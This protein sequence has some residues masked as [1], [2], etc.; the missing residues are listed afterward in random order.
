MEI[1]SNPY[2]ADMEE[3]PDG[4]CEDDFNNAPQVN[5]VWHYDGWYNVTSDI[6]STISAIANKSTTEN[7]YK[8]QTF[9]CEFRTQ[10]QKK[11][12]A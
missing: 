6:C 1:G 2:V 12:L 7:I 9:G 10:N 8:C 11:I 4:L 5:T 3:T